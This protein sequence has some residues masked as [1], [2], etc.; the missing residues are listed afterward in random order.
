MRPD[1]PVKRCKCGDPVEA[2][3]NECWGCRNDR[4][5]R[6]CGGE[7]VCASC[8]EEPAIKGRTLCIECEHDAAEERSQA[9]LDT[10]TSAVADLPELKANL[11]GPR[12][13]R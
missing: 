4:L 13:T 6:K 8:V 9:E 7:N 11:L 10:W 12:G 2:G 3:R 5:D 1:P